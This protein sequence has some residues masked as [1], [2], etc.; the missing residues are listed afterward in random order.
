[1]LLRVMLTSLLLLIP[2]NSL[3]CSC[4]KESLGKSFEIYRNVA[5]GEIYQVVSGTKENPDNIVGIFKTTTIL[6]GNFISATEVIGKKITFRQS[7][8]GCQESPN[9]GKYLLFSNVE[10]EAYLGVC[11]PSFQVVSNKME[12]DILERMQ[13]YQNGK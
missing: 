13:S 11:K 3:A 10:D 1:M 5:I 12:K 8:G 4:I 6:K 9:K 2:L 7:I